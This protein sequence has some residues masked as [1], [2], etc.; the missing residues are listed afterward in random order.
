MGQ[1]VLPDEVSVV[2]VASAEETDDT[3]QRSER[4]AEATVLSH[5]IRASYLLVAWRPRSGLAAP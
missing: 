5:Y 1:T 2:T 3:V 4:L